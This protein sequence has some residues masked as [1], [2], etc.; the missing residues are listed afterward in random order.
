MDISCLKNEFTMKLYD[1]S[2]PYLLFLMEHVEYC[3][4]MFSA[5]LEVLMTVLLT[6][7]MGVSILLHY[8]IFHLW[9]AFMD[10]TKRKHKIKE[11]ICYNVLFYEKDS[12]F[13]N[14]FLFNRIKSSSQMK[15]MTNVSHHI[16]CVLSG[17]YREYYQVNGSNT[18]TQWMRILRNPGHCKY[19][20]NG[21]N[22]RIELAEN[23]NINDLWIL[24]F[25]MKCKWL[26]FFNQD[27]LQNNEVQINYFELDKDYDADSEE[28]DDE[29]VLETI[30]ENEN[31][32]EES[33]SQSS[34]I[35]ENKEKKEEVTNETTNEANNE[36]TNETT[37]EIQETNE[38]S[39]EDK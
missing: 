37:N 4:D 15:L 20:I 17:S 9:D 25:Q 13:G 16:T 31:E 1:N 18:T 38:M 35:D 28:E 5:L 14:V 22:Y 6:S 3:I 36:T 34:D 7:L 19:E 10:Y 26:P 21:Q 33:S 27:S 12:P 39:K 30:N 11:G 29:N 23:K 32:D 8:A 2:V 24:S